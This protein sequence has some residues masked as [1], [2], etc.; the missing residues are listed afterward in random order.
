MPVIK[1]SFEIDA[2]IERAFDLSRSIDFHAHSQFNHE[3]KAV[4]GVKEGLIEL[5]ET[6]TWR[7]RHF[8]ISQ[9]LTARISVFERPYRFRDTMEK[10]AFKRFDH[11]HIFERKNGKTIMHDVF[12]YDSPLAFLGKIFDKLILEKYMTKFFI[13]RNTLMKEILESDQWRDFLE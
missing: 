10:G 8:G 9:H 12:D 13:D 2:P 4:D 3:E 7:A 1:T 5:G 6:V 11:D